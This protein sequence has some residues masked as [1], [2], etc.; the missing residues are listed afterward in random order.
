LAEIEELLAVGDLST[1]KVAILDALKQWTSAVDTE[2]SL[3]N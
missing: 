3:S 2:F 1:E